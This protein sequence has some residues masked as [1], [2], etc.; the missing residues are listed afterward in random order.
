MWQ[1][2]VSYVPHN[3]TVRDFLWRIRVNFLMC[4]V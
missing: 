4:G 3:L 1:P 2:W